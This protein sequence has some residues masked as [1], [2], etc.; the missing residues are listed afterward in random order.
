MHGNDFNDES[1]PLARI[2]DDKLLCLH[3]AAANASEVLPLPKDH[4]QCKDKV[5]T[6]LHGIHRLKASKTSSGII[7]DEEGPR[8]FMAASIPTSER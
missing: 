6:T 2:E 5:S 3:T 8:S 1:L 4:K 7:F